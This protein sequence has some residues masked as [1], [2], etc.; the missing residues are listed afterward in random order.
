MSPA[1]RAA[2]EKLAARASS[3]TEAEYLWK[4]AGA[5]YGLGQLESFDAVIHPHGNNTGWLEQHLD[6]GIVTT[7]TTPG[8]GRPPPRTSIS[9]AFAQAM[10]PAD[11]PKCVPDSTVM[12]RLTADPVLMLGVSTGQGPAAI[13]AAK[14]G[15]DSQPALAA[16]AQSLFS[17]NYAYAR[18]VD[19]WPG[20]PPGVEAHKGGIAL[21]NRLL[22]PVTGST[23]HYQPLT[24][25]AD[26]QAA[27]PKIEA[28]AQAGEPVPIDVRSPL[29]GGHQMV[30][31]DYRDG[32]FE[33]YNPWGYTQWV[34]TQQFVDAE[35]GDLTEAPGR[36]PGS[37]PEPVAVQLPQR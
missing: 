30:I 9:A 13:G 29:A 16:R 17:Q 3:L 36:G 8:N 5:G 4:A 2:F 31:E 33:I 20:E 10:P 34:P 12:A 22:T 6:P 27:L 1:D 11:D 25:T 37:F 26:R 23:Y 14:A 28:A 32:E 18:A 19:H 21:A 15:D 35:L 7:M 24:D